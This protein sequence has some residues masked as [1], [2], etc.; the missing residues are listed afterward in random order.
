MLERFVDTPLRFWFRLAVVA[1]VVWFVIA[2]LLHWATLAR[3][4]VS[5]EMRHISSCQCTTAST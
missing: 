1:S 2:S 3:E 5:E 4:M